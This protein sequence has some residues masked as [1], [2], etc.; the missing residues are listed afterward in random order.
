MS[1]SYDKAWYHVYPTNDIREH[2]L[3]SAGEVDLMSCPCHPEFDAENNVIIHN[4][5]DGREAYESGQR[6]P[7]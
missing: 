1:A 5:F 7:H 6:K 4:S 3:D 2:V